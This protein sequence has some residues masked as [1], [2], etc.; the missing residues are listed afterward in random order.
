MLEYSPAILERYVNFMNNPDEDTAVAQFGKGDKY[1][2]IATMMSTLPGLPM[3]GHGQIEGF[4]EKYGM[5][6]TRAYVDESPDQGLIDYHER[7]IFPIL[8]ERHKFCGVDH[9]SLLDFWRDG[10]VDENVF[11]FANRSESTGEPSL[12]L[13]NNA[14]EPTGCLLYTSPSPRDRQKSRMPSSA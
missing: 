6:F 14:H 5:E 12:V 1:F 3:F 4:S 9:F 11:A 8:R 13:Y 10:R 7:V 2:G